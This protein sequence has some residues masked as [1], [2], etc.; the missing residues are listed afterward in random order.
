MG[1]LEEKRISMNTFE[2]LENYLTAGRSAHFGFAVRL[3]K[4]AD[5]AED[6]L[7]EAKIRAFRAITSLKSDNIPDAWFR[8][9]IKNCFLDSRRYNSRRPQT[10]SFDA[11]QE[12]NPIFDVADTTPSAE[13]VM[14]AED[15]LSSEVRKAL[16]QLP[17]N[18]QKLVIAAM[19]GTPYTELSKMFRCGAFKIRTQLQ[20]AHRALRRQLMI[21]QMKGG[22]VVSESY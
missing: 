14:L 9:I 4:N 16:G 21:A 17:E 11:I 18:Q 13:Q 6:L 15:D 19:N 20:K 7:Q 2:T 22:F 8:Q 10:T 5:D 12:A 3:T 1:S